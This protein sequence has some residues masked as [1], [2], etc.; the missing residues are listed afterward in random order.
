MNIFH[1]VTL[2]T[3]KKNKTRTLVTIIGIILSVAM[4][5]AVTTSISTLQNYL[6]QVVVASD[7]GWHGAIEDLSKKELEE[8]RSND[9]V[10]KVVSIQSIGYAKL[11]GSKNEDKPY[12]FIG[13][14]ENNLTDL[15]PVKVI[16]GRMPQNSTEIILPEHLKNNGGVSYSIGDVL[17]LDVGDRMTDGSILNQSNSYEEEKENFTKRETKAYTIVGICNRPS[18]EN[19]S[20]P[21]YTALTISDGT[22]ADRYNG[23]FALHKMSGIYAFMK[24]NYTGHSSHFNNE[25]LRY[26]G[27]STDSNYLS[28]MYSLSAILILIIM[29]GSISLIYNSFSISVSER[30]KQFGLL[31][32]IGATKRQILRSVL[33]EALVLCIIGIPVG[34]LSGIAGIGVTLALSKNLFTSII[35]SETTAVFG[36]HVSWTAVLAASLVGL[37]TVLIS[38]YIPAKKAVRIPAIESIRQTNDI[39]IRPH[40]VRTSRLTYRFFGLEGMIASKNFKR[41]RKKYRATVVS[42]FMS[43]VLFISAS[44][45]CDYLT[46]SMR[47]VVDQTEFDITYTL[48]PEEALKSPVD[49]L[50]ADL[51]K[52]NGVTDGE[53]SYTNYYDMSMPASNLSKEY[54]DYLNKSYDGDYLGSLQSKAPRIGVQLCFV[55]DAAYDRFLK[56]NQLDASIF[57][58]VENPKA[59]VYDSSKIYDGKEGKYYSFHLLN[60]R[61]DGG[62]LSYIREAINGYKQSG[63]VQNGDSGDITAYVYVNDAGD[64]MKVSP[65]EANGSASI[66]IGA[67]VEKTPFC[68]DTSNYLGGVTLIY[69]CSAMPAII[70][71]KV[72]DCPVILYFKAPSHKAAYKSLTVALQDRT[73]STS[74][75]YDYAESAE[76]NRAL[77]TIINIFSYGFIILISL[78]AVANVFNTISTNI[79]LRRREFAMLKSVGMTKRGFNKMMNFECILYG[80]KGLLY[81]IPVAIGVTFLIYRSIRTGLETSFYI[82]WYSIVISIG[83][84]FAVVFAT[85]IYSMSKIKKDNPIDALKNE[86][87]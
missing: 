10:D 36:L 83:S 84:V 86:N 68:V 81:G 56:D 67:Y 22:G 78:I 27:V 16:Q 53:Y 1:K 39:S 19:Y 9:Q 48:T 72:S 79:N 3:L 14:V 71:S 32:S 82:P 30:I 26:S 33:F 42:L 25:Y 13:A 74:R 50:I 37:V 55:D 12:L 65:D 8:L 6:V 51:S 63:K 23:Y 52:I 87:L 85:M 28:V 17:T 44:S 35:Y 76:S 41:N 60:G 18:F 66:Q 61:F 77:V 69:P 7:G 75:L 20:A 80:V 45:F 31:K 57:K 2:Q 62:E 40:K 46:S 24:S 5:T 49:G 34:V 47:T 58:N 4:F 11:V 29:F 70:E 64:S 21:G 43:V 38:A 15:L 54:I 73:L 59:L